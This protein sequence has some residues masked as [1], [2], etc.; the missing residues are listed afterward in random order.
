[1]ERIFRPISLVYLAIA[2]AEVTLIYFAVNRVNAFEAQTNLLHEWYLDD[3][4]HISASNLSALAQEDRLDQ[5]NLTH[6]FDRF[7]RLLPHGY[8]EA[9]SPEALRL[10]FTVTDAKG[11]VHFDS[12]DQTLGTDISSRPEVAAALHGDSQ[13]RD[14]VADPD[15]AMFVAVPI[16]VDGKIMGAVIASKTNA[17]LKP[18]VDETKHSMEFVGL[19][20]AFIVILLIA[21]LFLIFLR[22]IELWFSYAELFKHG[23]HP[24]RPNLRR[25]RFGIF[26][27]ALDHIFEALSNRRYIENMMNCLAHEMRNPVGSIQT[28]AELLSRELSEED[29]N[30]GIRNIHAETQ[31]MDKTI[32]KLLNLAALEKRDSLKELQHIEVRYILEAI[33]LRFRERMADKGIA[34][35]F[36][37]P[38]GLKIYCE[39]DLLLQALGNLIQNSIDHSESG[40]RIDLWVI[41]HDKKVEFQVIDQGTGI[42]D[43]A[44]D[45][46]FDKF[47][48]IKA[49]GKGKGI[50]LGLPLVQEVADLHYGS[51]TLG[52]HDSGGAIAILTLM[53]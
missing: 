20:G 35:S 41:E 11:I 31:R 8:P 47:Y 38:P 37:A 2:I 15:M 5:T 45:H 50:G 19:T 33:D 3:V 26:G 34:L 18:L 30:M 27:E 24:T 23:L 44:K 12:E 14:Q 22:P 9:G 43:F 39:P 29:F 13:R 40:T 6:I 53:K 17:I 4:A 28:S 52:N 10:N 32:T 25:T 21:S 46:V 51:I 36:D 16:E 48:S 7:R 1:M 49:R 42:P